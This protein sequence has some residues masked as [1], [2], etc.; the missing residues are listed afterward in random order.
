VSPLSRPECRLETP[1]GWSIG[2][3]A[4]PLVACAA[5]ACETPSA[6]KTEKVSP[7]ELARG[8]GYVLPVTAWSTLSVGGVP[9]VEAW[10]STLPFAA[11]LQNRSPSA[12]RAVERGVL[13]RRLLEDV[14]KKA[15][16][17]RPLSQEERAG[18]I[19]TNWQLFDAPRAVRSAEVFLPVRLVESTDSALSRVTRLRE[20]ALGALSIEDLARRIQAAAQEIGSHVSARRLPPLASDGRVVVRN[21]SDD[22][23]IVLA[24]E[25]LSAISQLGRPGEV[26]PIVPSESGFHFF[27]A[28]EVLGSEAPPTEPSDSSLAP[29]VAA[30]RAAA[31]LK[32]LRETLRKSTELARNSNVEALLDRIGRED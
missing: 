11:D 5:F 18:V 19:H 15:L 29:L 20:G 21:P 8:A 24:P 1:R 10:A 22:P 14:S 3:F 30:E 9:A 32:R 16:D 4:V 23:K 7:S 31:P 6:P 13:V 12:Y 27:Y 2:A 26:T 28:V 25:M 17:E